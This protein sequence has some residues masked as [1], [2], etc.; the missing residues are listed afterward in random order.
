[1][2]KSQFFYYRKE[3]VKPTGENKEVTFKTYVD[4]FNVDAVLRTVQLE[5]ERRYVLLND[6]HERIIEIPQLNK[7]GEQ[8]SIIN[9]KMTAQSEIYLEKADAERFASL[10]Q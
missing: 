4:S 2:N 8:T 7:K 10:T 1:M 9:K 3:I 6:V 5:D